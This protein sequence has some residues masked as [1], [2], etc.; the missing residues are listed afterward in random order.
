M[1]PTLDV[2][3]TAWAIVAMG[4][5]VGA[6]IGAPIT[7]TLLVFELTDDYALMAD[8]VVEARRRNQGVPDLPPTPCGRA[9]SGMRKRLR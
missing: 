8:L 3:P 2:Q 5:V 1:L 7:A 4:G 6:A 9:N